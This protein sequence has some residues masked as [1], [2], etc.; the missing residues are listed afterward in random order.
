MRDV[1][2]IAHFIGL[3][4]LIGTSFAFMFLRMASS[5]MEEKEAQKFILNTFV[6]SKMAHI[7]LALLIISGGYLMT[8]YWNSL[9]SLPLLI[10]KL[11]LVLALAAF[12]GMLSSAAKK[13]K[14]GDAE[15]HL[16]RILPLGRLALLTG[17]TIV[18][19]AVYV[20]H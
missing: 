4:M 2:L 16:K 18:I 17:L 1:M 9:A 5:R 20:F 8:P 13:A 19:L 6:L 15:T 14:K 12:V 7:G 3:V 11:A 10:A